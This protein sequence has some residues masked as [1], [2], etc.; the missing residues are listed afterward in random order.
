MKGKR[1]KR[2]VFKTWRWLMD[3]ELSPPENCTCSHEGMPAGWHAS[4]CTVYIEALAA[5]P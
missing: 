5:K 4:Y 1:E 3:W 2:R